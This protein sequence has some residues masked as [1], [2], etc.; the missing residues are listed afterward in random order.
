MRDGFAPRAVRMAIS[1]RRLA[2]CWS[3]L[4]R[5]LEGPGKAKPSRE[6]DRLSGLVRE[7]ASDRVR[8][9]VL[10]LQGQRSAR[11]RRH[12]LQTGPPADGP[13]GG[14]TLKISAASTGSIAREAAHPASGRC[15]Q[16]GAVAPATSAAPIE[17][18]QR[19]AA[20]P[21]FQGDG[22][23]HDAL[24]KAG[25]RVL[26]HIPVSRVGLA[27]FTDSAESLDERSEAL[28]SSVLTTCVL[29]C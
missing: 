7:P 18:H 24:R 11:P 6:L 25:T 4:E 8:G 13:H 10:E 19:I 5:C 3:T 29:A 1:R 16:P 15:R 26:L 27:E 14:G 28:K 12:G 2:A 21:S 17:T 9:A 20:L 23:T 22:D